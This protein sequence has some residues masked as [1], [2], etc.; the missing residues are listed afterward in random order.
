MDVS[1]IIRVFWTGKTLREKSFY[2]NC[3]LRFL[4]VIDTPYSVPLRGQLR[5]LICAWLWHPWVW[6]Y[7]PTKLHINFEE[8]LIVDTLRY[9][10]KLKFSLQKVMW[11]GKHQALFI[12]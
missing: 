9:D 1:S 2:N 8:E 3:K 6:T 12:D 11:K 4:A 5:K 7:V 10:E